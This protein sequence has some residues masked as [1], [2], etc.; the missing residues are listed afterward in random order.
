MQ[1]ILESALQEQLL[2]VDVDVEHCC[3]GGSE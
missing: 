3:E 1:V 2:G